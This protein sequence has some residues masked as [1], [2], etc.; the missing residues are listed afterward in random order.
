MKNQTGYSMVTVA[1]YVILVAGWIANIV[2]LFAMDWAQVT[3]LFVF[4]AIG[5]FVPWL[6]AVLGFV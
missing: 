4:R 3:V 2:K 5:V 6:G 1:I